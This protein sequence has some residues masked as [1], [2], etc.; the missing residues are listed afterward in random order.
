MQTDNNQQTTTPPGTALHLRRSSTPVLQLATL[1]TRC[2]RA[3]GQPSTTGQLVDG[4]T[5]DTDLTR[6]VTPV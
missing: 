3:L 6:S 4:P 5:L 2:P 1:R